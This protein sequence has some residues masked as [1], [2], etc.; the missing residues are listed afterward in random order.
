MELELAKMQTAYVDGKMWV[1][2][3]CPYCDHYT[4]KKMSNCLKVNIKEDERIKFKVI[5]KDKNLPIYLV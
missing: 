3:W 2:Y 1:G 4:Y 5:C